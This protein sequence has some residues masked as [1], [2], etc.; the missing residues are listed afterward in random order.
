MNPTPTWIPATK[1]R[2]GRRSAVGGSAAPEREA[3][4]FYDAQRAAFASLRAAISESTD[5][6]QD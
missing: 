3:Q 6:D 2:Q 5:P 4:A 1:T